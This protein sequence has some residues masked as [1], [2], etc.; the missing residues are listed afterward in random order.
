MSV[1]PRIP[2]SKCQAKDGPINC[3]YHKFEIIANNALELLATD[4]T[5]TK[6]HDE[7]FEA[8]KALEEIDKNEAWL[9]GETPE[10]E[11]KTRRKTAKLK[12]G[13]PQTIK[14]FRGIFDMNS[15]E[16]QRGEFVDHVLIKSERDPQGTVFSRF[17][18]NKEDRED[19]AFPAEP[20]QIRIQA[21]RP[22]TADEAQH[23]AGLLGYAYRITIAGESLGSPT[24]DTPYSFIVFADTTKSQR[25]DLGMA[26]EELHTKFPLF[27][28][29]G[30]PQRKTK[31]NTRLVEGFNEKDLEVQFY[32]DA[33]YTKDAFSNQ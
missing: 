16:V 13:A 2:A 6:L 28:Q 32:Y 31:E 4:P 9:N 29:E 1:K 3:P 26:L 17:F 14:K 33:V 20:Y 22:L 30:S 5:N 10:D 18:E 8:R 12:T 27:V 21:N 15:P 23:M 11:P 19:W 24:Q 7:Y 25:D